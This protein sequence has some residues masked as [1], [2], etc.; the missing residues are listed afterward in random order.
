[1]D[2]QAIRL[3]MFIIH[4]QTGIHQSASLPVNKIN[5]FYYLYYSYSLIKSLSTVKMH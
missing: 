3:A 1:M 5:N 2:M 4:S